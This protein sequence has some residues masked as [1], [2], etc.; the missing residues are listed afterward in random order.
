M[1]F[2]ELI[3]KHKKEKCSKC[4]LDVDC[5]ITKTTNGKTR[6]TYEEMFEKESRVFGT[7]KKM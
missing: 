3:E 4:K 2:A 6:C 1:S 7:D 5:Q